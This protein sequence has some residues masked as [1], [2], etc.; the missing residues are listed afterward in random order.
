M[1]KPNLAEQD[2]LRE[3]ASRLN[4]AGHGQKGSIVTNACTHLSISKQE[5]YRRLEEVGYS[6]GRKTRADKG[7][8]SVS[9]ETAAT[10]GAMVH[11][12]TRANGKKTMP[13]KLALDILKSNGQ[14]PD[15]SAATIGRAMK[16]NLCHP[17]QLASPSAHV[18]QRSLHPNHVW[19]ADASVCVVFYLPK[20]GMQVMDEKKFYKNKPANL[21]KIENERVI[22]YVITDHTSGSIYVEYVAGSE[23]SANLTKVF[24]NAIQRRSN[25]EPMS[26]VPW[27][28]YMDKGSAN[29]SGL[30]LNL[31][32]N[33]QVEWIAHGAGNPRAKGQVEQG[34]NLV[35]TQYEGRLRFKEIGSIDE[36][37]EDVAKWRAYWN[38]TAIH[39]R[40]KKT[41]NQVWQTITNE[42][43]RVAPSL[44]LCRELVN[45][46]PETKTVQGDLTIKHSIK[47]FGEHYYKVAHIE[48]VYVKAKLEIVVNPY[49]APCIDVITT[50]HE[51]N[52]IAITCEPDQRDM[53]GYSVD[54]PIIGQTTKSMPD[55][56]IDRNRKEIIKRAYGADTLA[57]AE[58]AIKQKKPAFEG[59][60]D[61]NADVKKVTVNEYLPRAGEQMQTPTQKRELAALTHVAA[62]K[63]IKALVGDIWTA[64]HYR[65]LVMTHPDGVPPDQV[66]I[67]ANAIRA[68]AAPDAA[69]TQPSRT[70]RVVGL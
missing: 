4:N 70:L 49:R 11:L 10:V 8:S 26:G 48:G 67:I 66:E 35:E 9:P 31:L 40:T 14:A 58:K 1:T 64:D 13:I 41:R 65:A 22:R 43:L 56:G 44:E 28:L 60:F 34:N 3:T 59:Q 57:Q 47:G 17:T 2:Y 33:L 5:L 52:Q 37:N 38:E 19:Q 15:V 18:M 68:N 20:G 51:G 42:Q 55:S 27:I 25:Q 32:K 21:K 53:F 30:F 62:A 45:T 54:A 23:D 16:Q 69:Q 39:S 50:D 29:M 36:L 24:L 7:R 12:A 6:T 46:K 61:V 63:R